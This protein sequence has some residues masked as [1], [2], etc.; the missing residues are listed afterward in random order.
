MPPILLVVWVTTIGF[1]G[2]LSGALFYAKSDL[3]L[4]MSE[5]VDTVAQMAA[6]RVAMIFDNTDRMLLTVIGDLRAAN[7]ELGRPVPDSDLPAVR[8]LL[9]RSAAWNPGVTS[10]ALID[11]DGRVLVD[12]GGHSSV[13][14]IGDQAY[15]QRLKK[16]GSH[17]SHVISNAMSDPFSGVWGV[18]MARRIVSRDDHFEGALVAH[19]ELN[20]SFVRF[21]Q[22]LSESD[23]DL[24][25][26][27]HADGGLLAEFPITGDLLAG[28]TD[29]L[30]AIQGGSFGGVAYSNSSL[31]GI[32]RLVA[33]HRIVGYRLYLVYGKNVEELL[34]TWRNQLLTAVIVALLGL[35]GSAIVTISVRR[36]MLL[37][38]QLEMARSH[39]KDSNRALR[40]ALAASEL[41]AA[42]DQLTGLW[43]R[44]TFDHRL[45][46]AVA[47]RQRHDGTFSLLLIDMDH[48]KSI[49][50]RYGHITGDEALKH[51]AD[52]L[53]ERLRQ[54]DVDARWGGEEFA[55]LADGANLERAFVLAEQIREAVENSN[56]AGLPRLTVS[57]G[58]AECQ[59][60][61]TSTQVLN[62]ADCA[63]YEAKR[64]GRNRVAAAGGGALP[65]QYYFTGPTTTAELFGETAAS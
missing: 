4:R 39:L 44:R 55:V 48:F 63:L 10:L 23:K 34:A 43:N 65:A 19:I 36:Q 37:T 53:H 56:F 24:I 46:E 30:K 42:K 52:V 11:V 40:S 57:I 14:S 29:I 17:E 35:A 7:I 28:D 13:T 20:K 60:G 51:F 22:G 26:L 54:N 25:A 12:S 49:N 6:G 64:T 8:N 16:S 21:S 3:K 50:D 45:H 32:T 59:A 33:F 58:L 47:H 27:R 18:A 61:E 62:R 38:A 2:V 15:F 41:T 9:A 1:I 5:Q 31:D